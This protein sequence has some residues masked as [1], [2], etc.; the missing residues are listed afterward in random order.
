MVDVLD[1]V[2]TKGP[3]RTRRRKRCLDARRGAAEASSRPRTNQPRRRFRPQVWIVLIWIVLLTPPV[4][5]AAWWSYANLYLKE[6]A[7]AETEAAKPTAEAAKS[8]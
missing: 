7:E 8:S 3:G 5:F 4:G 2:K 6:P 1:C